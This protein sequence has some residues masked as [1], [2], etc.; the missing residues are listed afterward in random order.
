MAV[1][2][3]PEELV[4]VPGGGKEVQA[5][6]WVG[7]T[8]VPRVDLQNAV[9]G[10]CLADEVGQRLVLVRDVLEGLRD[11][12]VEIIAIG[13]LL[14]DVED[15]Q[16][17]LLQQVI[18][19]L[20]LPFCEVQEVAGVRALTWLVYRQLLCPR[21]CCQVHGIWRCHDERRLRRDEVGLLNPGAVGVEAM[22]TV[23]PSML[24]LDG[25][26]RR[27]LPEP[28]LVVHHGLATDLPAYV[29]LLHGV[30]DLRGPVR[31]LSA[32]MRWKKA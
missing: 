14:L 6:W 15:G 13:D 16:L 26:M 12:V 23:V 5:V 3:L 17:E 7:P 4:G 10:P 18:L 27:Y 22:W 1:E 32:S 2:L 25:G 8:D 21:G 20:L 30:G 24:L 11:E 29:V 31:S 28:V 9:P 19:I